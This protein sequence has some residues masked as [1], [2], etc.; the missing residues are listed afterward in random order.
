MV[1]E[2]N[3]VANRAEADKKRGNCLP[4]KTKS[5]EFLTS[6]EDQAPIATVMSRYMMIAVRSN[7]I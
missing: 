4:A 7:L 2:P 6:L 1:S 3:Q 5:L